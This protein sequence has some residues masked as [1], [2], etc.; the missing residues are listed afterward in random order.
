MAKYKI[1]NTKLNIDDIKT[2][3]IYSNNNGCT[4]KEVKE[5]SDIFETLITCIVIARTSENLSERFNIYLN[6][7]K[8]SREASGKYGNKCSNF[9]LKINRVRQES[10][11]DE[12]H[13]DFWLPYDCFKGVFKHKITNK[14]LAIGGAITDSR[15]EEL[16]FEQIA[17]I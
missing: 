14:A 11:D 7:N 2:K 16:I 5:L 4:E 15:G 12:D 10:D 8:I 9:Q 13:A 1:T 6:N 3:I 17:P